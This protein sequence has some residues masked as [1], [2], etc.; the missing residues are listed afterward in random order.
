MHRFVNGPNNDRAI[1][2]DQYRV[3]QNS[4]GRKI[5]QAPGIAGFL[6]PF[7]CAPKNFALFLSIPARTRPA[8][9]TKR[10]LSPDSGMRI[11]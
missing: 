11:G 10:G 9:A 6:R 3:R 5:I 4:L 8:P 7:L 1:G 2:A